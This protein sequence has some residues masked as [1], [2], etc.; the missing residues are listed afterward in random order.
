MKLDALGFSDRAGVRRG[1]NAD[2]GRS[3]GPGCMNCIVHL[4][5]WP[6]SGKRTIGSIL[7]ARLGARLLDVH[8]ILN[9]AEALF[10]RDDP[11]H[12]ALR[13][14]VR[15]LVLDYAAKL[16]S[17]MSLILT[18]PL[19][20]DEA[21]I[22]LFERFRDL[23]AQRNARL[24]S[25]V[26]D[27]GL[28]ENLRR[29]QTPSRAEHRKLTRPDVLLRMRDRYELLRPQGTEIMTLDITHLSAD[30]AAACILEWIRPA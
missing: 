29:L 8:V 17:G 20:A 5:G 7:A 14:G 10:E 23:A 6:G 21:D 24:V 19:A 30:D 18:D 27:I 3:R 16:A 26:L 1:A 12:A 25:I 22:T 11:L 4:N 9:P 2:V 15:S 13:E 28:G